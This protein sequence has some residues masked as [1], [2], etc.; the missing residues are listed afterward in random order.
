MKN[1]VYYLN[2]PGGEFEAVEEALPEPEPGE[3][4]VRT[5]RTSICQSD[6]I[7]YRSGY[8]LTRLDRLLMEKLRESAKRMIKD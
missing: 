5:L 8:H 1:L 4:R 3:I 6:V 7:I 2:R